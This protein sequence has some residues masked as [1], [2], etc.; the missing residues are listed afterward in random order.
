MKKLLSIFLVIAVVAGCSSVK[1]NKRFLASG[2]YDQAIALAVKKL[3][4]NKTSEKKDAHIAILEKAFKKAAEE[5]TRR[6][7]FLKKDDN[8][9]NIRAL[10]YLHVDL[11]DR[12]D[13]IRPLLP[14]YSVS[15]GRDASF[16]MVD[17]T[18][19]LLRSKKA[20]LESLYKE[21]QAYMKRNTIEDYR[22]AYHVFCDITELQS[23]YLDVIDLK[24]DAHY[25]GTNFIFVSLNN[26]S[27]QIIPVRLEREL[28]D[29]NTYGLGDFWT[30]YHSIRNQNTP[31]TFGIALNFEEIAISPERI[32]ER[33]EVRTKEI[34]TGSV[35][36]RDRNGAIVNDENG[37][38]ISISTFETV[39]ADVRI[40]K[41][42]KSVFVGVAVTYR[43]LIAMRN[44]NKYP[45]S[46]EFVFENIF[47]SFRGDKRALTERDLK[48]LR[49]GSVAF[50]SNEQMVLDA[51]TDI[52]IRLKETLKKH[53]IY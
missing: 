18:D 40:T 4:K 37:D 41:Q 24:E 23:D 48:L 38:P 34:K 45:L 17:N 44:L 5:D 22:T 43:D 11:A 25:R 35:L 14:L 9:S 29:F 49:N 42:S 1:K 52:K 2:K 15:L 10:Y 50:P 31:Y 21:A 12:Q 20:Y 30:E 39:S 16:Q 26:L 33:E 27:E 19:A 53:Q 36:K 8:P 3:R 46:S 28:L 32:L 6:M 7:A 13:L 47:A 51:G